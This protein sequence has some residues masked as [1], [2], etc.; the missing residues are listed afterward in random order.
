MTKTVDARSIPRRDPAIQSAI[1]S[2]QDADD[3]IR[4]GV[5]PTVELI[6]AQAVVAMLIERH[7]GPKSARLRE[8]RAAIQKAEGKE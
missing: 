8:A 7:C 3:S 4:H 2:L 6:T 1:E 5:D